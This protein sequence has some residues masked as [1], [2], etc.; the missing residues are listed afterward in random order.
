MTSISHVTLE[1]SDAPAATDFYR[2]F[3]GAAFDA[4]AR[5]R[6]RASEA[7]T[8]GFRGF[9]L[10]VDV[11]NPASVDMV[12]HAALDAGAAPLKSPKKQFWGGYSAVVEA[13]DGTIWKVAT[14]A[15]RDTGPASAGIERIVLLL[16]VEDIA[17]S[18][19]FYVD[20]GLEVAKS[21]GNKYVEFEPGSGAVTL[22]L[23]KRRGLA[24]EFGVSPEGSGSRRLA[25]GATV[26]A[27]FTD[28]DG[29]AWEPA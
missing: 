4:D 6:V 8:S 26:A 22:G 25:I 7:P 2:D 20:H 9:T 1:V 28:P 21:Y 27:S 29:F 12:T 15:K 16:G 23:Y 17:A 14:A 13:P 11:A 18:K 10:G 19:R 24:K 3:H 5:V